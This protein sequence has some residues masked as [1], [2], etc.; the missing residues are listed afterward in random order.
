MHAGGVAD[1]SGPWNDEKDPFEVIFRLGSDG[2]QREDLNEIY[3]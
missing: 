3:R 1:N 2:S